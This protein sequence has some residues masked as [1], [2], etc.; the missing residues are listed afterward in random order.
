MIIFA[1]SPH[2]LKYILYESKEYNFKIQ[3]YGSFSDAKSGLMK[4][5]ASEIYGFI[6][7]VDDFGTIDWKQMKEFMSLSSIVSD[8]SKKRKRFLFAVKNDSGMLNLFSSKDYQAI[9]F[10]LAKFEVMTDLFI[11]QEV[12]GT[13]LNGY[14]KPYV[15]NSEDNFELGKY[16]PVK[17]LSYVPLFSNT[18]MKSLERIKVRSTKNETVI[19]DE[20]LEVLKSESEF[21]Y[22]LRLFGIEKNFHS[23]IKSNKYLEEYLRKMGGGS[24]YIQYKMMYEYVQRIGI[25]TILIS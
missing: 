7:M 9:D 2:Y 13:I 17:S 12:F 24:M 20:Y 19:E 22:T 6:V 23:D 5:N 11:R 4:T 14:L 16:R 25:E 21:F 1:I 18:A 3:G 15:E 8:G 10:F